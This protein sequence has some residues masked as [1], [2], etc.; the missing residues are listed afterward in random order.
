MRC[1][2]LL[3]LLLAGPA[4]AEEPKGPHQEG[5]YGGVS[6]G[7]TKKPEEKPSAKTKRPPKGTL[8]WIGFEAKNGSAQ[9]FL[10]SPGPFEVSQHLENGTLVVHA[11]GLSRLGQNT[12][13]PIDT[14]FFDTPVERIVAKRV[15][16]ARATK[17]A[18]GHA[19]GI[20]LRITFKKGKEPKEAD[21]R[22]ATEADGFYY[23]Y[24][25]F[26]GVPTAEQPTLS[27]PEQ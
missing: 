8:S 13:R 25:T 24:L 14:R 4:F 19:A 18:A 20:E 3:S 5:D 10:Q 17:K 9:V 15:G 1:A 22:S 23:T 26:Q 12:W 2:L 11:Q 7:E 6:P 16:A 21:V 27:T